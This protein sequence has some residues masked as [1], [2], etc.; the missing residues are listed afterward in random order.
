MLS[1][2][3]AFVSLLALFQ[4]VADTV[5][6]PPAL[7]PV[8]AVVLSILLAAA[9]S[10]AASSVVLQL[11]KKMSE[12]IDSLPKLVKQLIALPVLGAVF[13]Y[14]ARYGLT[15]PADLNLTAD[16]ATVLLSTGMAAVFYKIWRLVR[17]VGSEPR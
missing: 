10:G 8:G 3:L 5:A 14:L 15:I 12:T 16:G 11:F 7:D 13:A 2:I 1:F 17:P 9:K 4:A 6:A